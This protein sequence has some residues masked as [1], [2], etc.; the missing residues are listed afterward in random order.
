[1]TA[2]TYA[3]CLDPSCQKRV[4]PGNVKTAEEKMNFRHL[5]VQAHG[6]G[7]E[8]EMILEGMEA[9]SYSN[10]GNISGDAKLLAYRRA[11]VRVGFNLFQVETV[12]DNLHFF[13]SVAKILVNAQRGFGATHYPGGEFS[14]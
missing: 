11:G 1:M 9:G 14:R 2:V 13:G 3:R 12:G 8:V 6:R 10:Q 4:L 5:F 7:N